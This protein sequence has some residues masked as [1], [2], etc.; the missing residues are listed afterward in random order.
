MNNEYMVYNRLSDREEKADR[1]KKIL[2]EELQGK[3]GWGLKLNQA[4][5][6]DIGTGSGQIA[7]YLSEYVKEVISVDIQD[8]RT[9]KEGYKFI[10]IREKKLPFKENNF[11]IIIS[12]QLIEHL[13]N[14]K[15]HIRE[16]WRVLKPNGIVYFTTPNKYYITEP[17][18]EKLFG[19]L[20][21]KLMNKYKVKLLS[22]WDI[23][24]L[25]RDYFKIKDYTQKMFL[26]PK[27]YRIPEYYGVKRH[28]A[29]YIPKRLIKYVT[30]T[31]VMILNVRK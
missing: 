29:K 19:T 7:Y 5:V 4:K 21:K 8:I 16:M 3:D 12:N 17:H 11:D 23:E 28:L 13:P 1:I 25:S 14:Q 2:E 30:P 27:Y 26:F 24:E 20:S 10:I 22:Y 15:N 18:S 31:F 9:K 6:L